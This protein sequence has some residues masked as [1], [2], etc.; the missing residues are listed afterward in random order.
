VTGGGA[1]TWTD[2]VEGGA[3]GWTATGGTW[4]DTSG[5]GW[6]TDSG[7]QVKAHYYLAEW[8][9]F[10]GFDEG[11][12]YAYDTTYSRDAWKVEKV[13][14]N[15]PGMLVWY[16][17]TAFG[18]VNHTTAAST[19]LP[20]HGAKG[21]LLIVDSHFDPYRRQGTAA[22]KDP[23]TLDNLPSRPQSSN[24]AFSLRSTYPFREC[25]EAEGEPYSEYCTDYGTQPGVSTFSDAQGWVPGIEVRGSSLFA[26]DVDASVVLPSVNNAPYTTRVVNPDGT[27]ATG[28]YG[29][30]LGFTVLGSGNPGDAG[31]SYG[32][33]I[34]ILRAAKDNSS[35]TVHVTPAKS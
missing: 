5:A 9:N 14:Y 3:N 27:P 10:D 16:R 30:N 4:T 2:D 1:T 26:R 29:R 20:S 25:L 24:A 7:T 23:S 32:V 12:K 8:R 22:A 15:A 17:D 28:F 31:V 19:A 11:L 35:A 18:N 13:K 33:T 21:G 34:K 6:H